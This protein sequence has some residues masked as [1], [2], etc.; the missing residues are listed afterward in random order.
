V[1]RQALVFARPG[2][3]EVVEEV[4]PAPGAGDLLVKTRVS[5]ISAGT[6]L[7]AYRGQLPAELA[8]DETLP[9]LAGSFRF[10]FRYGYS[11]AGV[12][13]AVGPGVDEAWRGRR[14]FAF[15]PHASA[16]VVPVREAFVVPEGITDEAAALLATAETACNLVLD[17]RPQLGERVAVFGQGVVGLLL[18]SIL[19]R[20]P[21]DALVAIEPD[22]A[23]AA[24]ARKLG[25]RVEEAGARAALG[26]DGADL[27]YEVSGQPA[28]LDAALAATGAEGRVVVGSF[29][30]DKRA[31]VNLG[32]HFHRG[33][34]QLHSSQVSHIGPGLRGRWDRAR[35]MA[36]AWRALARVPIAGLISHRVPFGEAAAAYSLVDRGDAGVV[37][38]LLTYA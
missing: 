5:A 8:V 22:P 36:T 32:G 29:Y 28:V 10:P 24:L 37:Q 33:R 4:C 11:A 17:G 1:K 7:L 9:A 34:L 26:G 19:A 23:R 21:L 18:T 35:R 2:A 15:A 6:E 16:F 27:T 38:V 25:A 31:A 14:V 13:E 3:V 30:G 12:V 20:F